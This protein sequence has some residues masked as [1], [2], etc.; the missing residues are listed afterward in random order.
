MIP[1]GVVNSVTINKDVVT[2]INAVSTGYA[3]ALRDGQT[4]RGYRW[5]TGEVETQLL[6]MHLAVVTHT[7]NPR[8]REAKAEGTEVL[9]PV[10]QLPLLI[11][12]VSHQRLQ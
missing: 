11:V 4:L 6:K 10:P 8:T 12:L 9:T 1:K 7:Y 5:L 2:H 3:A